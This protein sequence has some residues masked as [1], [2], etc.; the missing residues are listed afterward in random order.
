[1]NIEYDLMNNMEKFQIFG[2]LFNIYIPFKVEARFSLEI[3]LY[4]IRIE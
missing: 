2:G 4:Y 3:I 1:M